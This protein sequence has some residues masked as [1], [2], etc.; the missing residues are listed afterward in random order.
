MT[1][2]QKFTVLSTTSL[3]AL[4]GVVIGTGIARLFGL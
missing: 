3:A 2:T 1:I 4:T